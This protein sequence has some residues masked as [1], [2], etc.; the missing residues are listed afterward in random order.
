MMQAWVLNGA[1][2]IE[3]KELPIPA[4]Q[5]GWVLLKVKACGI[6]G[7][8]I[9]RIYDT[10]A[11]KH[12]LIP[13][14]E[15]AGIVEETG[16]GVDKA[17]TGSRVGVF[18]LIP[19]GVCPQ[20]V[21]KRYEMCDNYNYTG[22]RCDGAFA[23]YVCVPAANLIK[24]PDNVSFEQAA[25]LEPM[26]VAVHAMRAIG[27]GAGDTIAVC[28]LGTIGMLLYMFLRDAGHKDVFVI[29]NKD[30]QKKQ[31]YML[32]ADDAH[33]CD[34]RKEDALAWIRQRSGGKGA[35]VFFE[36][37]GRN[38][39]VTLGLNAA[40]K[41]GKLML[42]GNPHSDM[43]LMRNDYWQILRKQLRVQGTW[44]SSFTLDDN[45]D[46]HYVIRR[47]SEGDISPQELITHRLSLKELERGLHIMRDRSE[48]Y[49]K[50]M[51]MP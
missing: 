4:P 7:S 28:G 3:Y 27:A 10:G 44:N 1:N 25:M 5:E 15:F 36:C 24:L 51:I 45:D 6:C 33:Y 38:E 35:D 8:D 30:F 21:N 11:H 26:A 29:G 39:T 23:G 37:V 9:P 31:A 14:H 42:I 43:E 41:G 2:D 49:C 12:P 19:C 20:C 18:P 40:A 16:S 34:S 22:S 32:G 17:L 47:L 48:D 13:G 50:I 46:W